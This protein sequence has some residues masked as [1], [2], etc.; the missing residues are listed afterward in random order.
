MVAL[1]D[2]EVAEAKAKQSEAS[3][4]ATFEKLKAKK[5][6]EKTFTV[7]VNGEPMEITYRAISHQQYDDLVA[8]HPPSVEERA[9][10]ANYNDKTFPPALVAAVSI[11]PDLTPAQAREIFN[12]PDWSRGDLIVLF[13][14][15]LDVCNTG[16]DVPFGGPA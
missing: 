3:K 16:F 5:L 7:H 12:S 9:D 2:G 11:D 13:R 14:H 15:A 6:A 1:K 10:G 4:K 8:K